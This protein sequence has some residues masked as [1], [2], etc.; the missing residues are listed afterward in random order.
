MKYSFEENKVIIENIRNFDIEQ[1]LNCGQ[2]FRWNEFQDGTYKG[3]AFGKKLSLYMSNDNLVLE[4][5]NLEDFQNIWEGYFDLRTDYDKIKEELINN[6]V[7]KRVKDYGK[8]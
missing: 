1:T 3:T 2:C 7:Y 4:G 6:E 5:T 8:N